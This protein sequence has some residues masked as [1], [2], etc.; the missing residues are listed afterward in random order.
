MMANQKFRRVV[1]LLLILPLFLSLSGCWSYKELNNYSFVVA[2]GIDKGSAPGRF[3]VIEQIAV[4]S[5]MKAGS[6][7]GGGSGGNEAYWNVE[8]EGET[9]FATVRDITRKVQ[10]KP[11]FGH[12]KVLV[13]GR[14]IAKEG[15]F[16]YLDFFARDTEPRISTLMVVAK[17]T[18]TDILTQ[19]PHLE[20]LT[21]EKIDKLLENHIYNSTFQHVQMLGF[22]E[23]ML[24]ENK[25]A[26]VPII[27][28]I[29]MSVSEEE[30]GGDN[31]GK[32][33]KSEGKSGSQNP[34]GG[35]SSSTGNNKVLV[36]DGCAIFKD[37]KMV[38]QID[39]IQSRAYSFATNNAMGGIIVIDSPEG[40]EKLD[41]E[42][43]KVKGNIKPVIKGDKASIEIKVR[44]IAGIADQQSKKNY[45]T[46]EKLKKVTEKLSETVKKEILDSVMKSKEMSADYF[47][48]GNAIY[49]KNPKLWKKLKKNWDEELKKLDVQ[50]KVEAKIGGTSS[51][52]SIAKPGEG[53]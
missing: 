24:S 23:D 21:S 46:P 38:G 15:I 48:F 52:S 30:S 19:K 20:K 17:D 40:G 10:R 31:S 28:N 3:K 8:N 53:K 29:E 32:G 44:M 4:P 27:D 39:N 41:I 12:N 45:G 6:S 13:I 26:V 50:V 22:I 34:E 11:F 9:V 37:Y 7:K 16:K 2:T 35:Q 43:N 36:I 47:G 49:R 42:F 5:N 18:A 1:S 51:I 25:A 33:G 14:D